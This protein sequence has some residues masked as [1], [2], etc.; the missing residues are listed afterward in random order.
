MEQYRNYFQGNFQVQDFII[1]S[2]IRLIEGG[3][4]WCFPLSLDLSWKTLCEKLKFSQLLQT[5]FSYQESLRSIWN[6]LLNID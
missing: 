4:N 3:W 6:S 5:S 2:E 1:V